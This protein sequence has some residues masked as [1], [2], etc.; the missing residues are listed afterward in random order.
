ML[1][2]GFQ[3]GANLLILIVLHI[4]KIFAKKHS[5][6]QRPNLF[7]N[8]LEVRVAPIRVFP[9]AKLNNVHN[10]HT[11]LKECVTHVFGVSGDVIGSFAVVC[12]LCQPLLDGVAVRR[13]VVF[14]ST[15][16]T[17]KKR[18]QLNND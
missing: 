11:L 10:P 7:R 15:L 14:A 5:F 8:Q 1:K 16:E 4:E 3:E 13:R 2:K 17:G 12:A 18:Q 9:D 6:L